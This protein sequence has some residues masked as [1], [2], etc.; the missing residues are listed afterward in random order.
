[1]VKLSGALNCFPELIFA[2]PIYLIFLLNEICLFTTNI[3]SGACLSQWSYPRLNS[4]R[5]VIAIERAVDN[6]GATDL[7]PMYVVHISSII[8][9]CFHVLIK[10]TF[11]Q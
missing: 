2:Q 1:M 3:I 10:L 4:F 5:S 6:F 11:I 9:K 7:M 8:I